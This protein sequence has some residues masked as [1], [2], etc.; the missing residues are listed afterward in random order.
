MKQTLVNYPNKFRV[1]YAGKS[2]SAVA[3]SVSICAGAEQEPK[4]LSGVSHIIE[5]VLKQHLISETGVFGGV[6]ETKTDF[7]HIEI[8]ISTLRPYIANTLTILSSA[9]FDFNPKVAVFEREKNRALAEIEQ[10]NFN[11]MAILTSLTQKNMYKGTNLAT[12]VLGTEKTVRQMS[13]E[14]VK[15][16][17]KSIITPDSLILSMVGDICDRQMVE[18]S[19]KK[20]EDGNNFVIENNST[21]NIIDEKWI[22]PSLDRIKTNP[23]ESGV[24][25]I[26]SYSN[27]QE[28][29]NRLF[30]SRTLNLDNG[31]RKKKT[32]YTVPDYN[33]FVEKTKTLNQTRFQIS[34][35]SAPYNSA[36]YKYGKILE[37]YI[38][39]YLR[40]ELANAKG[41]YSLN[42]AIKQFKENG[43]ISITFA[44][45]EDK[46]SEVYNMVVSALVRLKTET[47]TTMEFNSIVTKYK[48]Q[49][50][51][52][53]QKITELA[54]RYNKWLYL[55]N[56]LFNL[57][58]EL[59]AID[60]LTYSNFTY[61]CN[62]TLDFT[63]MVV[64]CLG[65]K[66][67]NF[68]PFAPI[69]GK[70]K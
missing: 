6:V 62:Q 67:K 57:E 19:V 22:I 38:D 37:D 60:S 13:L 16:Y 9:I 55:K 45:D 39:T 8:T 58:N 14:E 2:A 18:P 21:D 42:V 29:V 46:A 70:R 1:V 12:E 4:N 32:K 10:S 49:V 34:F 54:L 31:K 47:V 25:I 40:T 53:H 66:M 41:V 11:P 63:R 35:P 27:V 61:I 24:K 33:V 28:L 48:T 26:G 50:A 3:I 65:R 43:H 52:K 64:V 59:I 36:G 51:L 44:V 56:R 5:R 15:E 68:E 17:Y 20:D 69:G 30:Y 7:E 23:N